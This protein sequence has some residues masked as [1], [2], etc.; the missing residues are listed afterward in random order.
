MQ[1]LS[2]WTNSIFIPKIDFSITKLRLKEF[3]ENENLGIVSRVDFVSFNNDF[4]V[5]RRAFVHFERFFDQRVM[6]HLM[7]NK[8][9]DLHMNDRLIR[10]LINKNPVPETELNFQQVASNTIFIGEEL[11]EQTKRIEALER[12]MEEK[13]LEIAMLQ[14][15]LQQWSTY[16]YQQGFWEET[17]YDESKEMM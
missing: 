3:L 11:K 4:G 14:G 15:A 12:R 6:E 17:G 13:N 7:E 9:Y 8:P 1:S 5:G 2:T 10:C 16:F